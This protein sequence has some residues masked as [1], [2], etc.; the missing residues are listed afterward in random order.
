MKPLGFTRRSNFRATYGEL[1]VVVVLVLVLR[2]GVRIAKSRD[3]TVFSLG[4]FKLH[5]DADWLPFPAKTTPSRKPN[6]ITLP[7][8]CMYYTTDFSNDVSKVSEG[9]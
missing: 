8:N 3:Y 9:L 1:L 6:G 4:I 2:L 7:S 5:V